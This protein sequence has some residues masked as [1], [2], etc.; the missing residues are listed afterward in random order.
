MHTA[1]EPVTFRRLT[2]AEVDEI[3]RRHERLVKL[4]PGGARAIFSFCDLSGLVLRE[5]VLTGANFSG[6]I[7]RNTDFTGADLDNAEF[8][9]A[10][11]TAARLVP[12][13]LQRRTC[14]AWCCAMQT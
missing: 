2:Q 6:A 4:W 14:A 1:I 9:G 3:C 13:S 12:A 11:L 5:R 7:L 8:F 10:D